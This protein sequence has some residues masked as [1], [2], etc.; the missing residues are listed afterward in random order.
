MW[1][2][3]MLLLGSSFTSL[4]NHFT[5]RVVTRTALPQNGIEQGK[6]PV[7]SYIDLRLQDYKEPDM[8]SGLGQEQIIFSDEDI[9][10]VNKP[11]FCQT[12][13]G[14]REKD[15]LA[16][17]IQ[18][19]FGMERVDHM[20]THRLDYATSGVIIFARNIE[21]LKHLNDQFR[22]RYKPIYKRYCALVHGR[23]ATMEGEINLPIGK[24]K[25][26]GPPLCTIDIEGKDSLTY[27]YVRAFGRNSTLVDLY[28]Q[29]GRTHQ[30]RIHL[31]SIGHPI[32][33]DLFYAP[34]DVFSKASRLLLH[35]EE[36]HITHPRT[37]EPIGFIAPCPFVDD[38]I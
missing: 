38:L 28:P 33:G 9:V 2:I 15:C 29:T 36:L 17:N 32:H 10:V 18:K 21:A 13:P 12:A 11:S 35:A 31:S 25:L 34:M 26:R 22:E 6:I 1:L 30:L 23:M 37:N 5:T 27:W 16:S 4:K 19:L 14:V 7:P 3:I 24:D 8:N 20:I